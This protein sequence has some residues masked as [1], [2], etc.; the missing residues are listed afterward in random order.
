M[1]QLLNDGKLYMN[2]VIESF[3][4]RLGTLRSGRA[5]VAMLYGITV[6]YYGSATPL[7]QIS[8]ISVVEGRQLMIKPFD[9]SSLKDIE[10][11]INNS[12]L[13][14]L[15]QNDGTVVRINVPSLTEETRKEVAKQVSSFAEEAKIAARNVRR[16]LN[17]EVKN[18][19]DLPE[20]QEKRLLE[21]IQKLTDETTKKIDTIS[22]DKTKEIMTI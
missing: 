16:D 20:D 17:D 3:E 2:D 14:L 4:S 8:Q 1:S 9:P 12:N 5:N 15:A 6:D 21:D 22:K 11:T 18:N 19:G 13:G 7:E 10:H